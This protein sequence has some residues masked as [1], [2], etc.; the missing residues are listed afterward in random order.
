MSALYTDDTVGFLPQRLHTREMRDTSSFFEATCGREFVK[1]DKTIS[2][3]RGEVIGFTF[4]CE[5][6]LVSLSVKAFL[7]MVCVLFRELPNDLSTD[8]RVPLKQLQRLSA[9]MIR[10]ADLLHFLRPFSRGAS[11]NTAGRRNSSVA[12]SA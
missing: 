10:N 8:T 2:A 5:L 4:D 11:A 9:L 12:L 7:K 6:R 3:P 1:M